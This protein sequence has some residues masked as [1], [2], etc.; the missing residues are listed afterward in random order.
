MALK[1]Y[2]SQIRDLDA[3]STPKDSTNRD[4]L[5]KITELKNNFITGIERL[6]QEE[7]SNFFENK[8]KQILS[9]RSKALQRDAKPYAGTGS[10]VVSA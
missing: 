5:E 7:K 6:I 9:K 8:R 3:P 10:K 4:T 1:F 2:H